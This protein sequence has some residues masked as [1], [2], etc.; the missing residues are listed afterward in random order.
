MM[1]QQRVSWAKHTVLLTAAFLLLAPEI[2]AGEHVRAADNPT[3]PTPRPAA[4]VTI[5]RRFTPPVAV[6]VVPVTVSV[7]VT[8][9][10]KP[11]AEEVY[12]DLR[13]P[14]GQRRTFSVEGGPGAIR[15]QPVMVL[16]PG[17]SVTV[18]LALK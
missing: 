3:A 1:S 2:L 7:A 18:R 17:Q 11:A 16:R 4:P 6:V 14:D 15:T 8:P 5:A 9:P 13:G 12:V 10:A